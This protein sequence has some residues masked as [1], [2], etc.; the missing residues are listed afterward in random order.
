MSEISREY[1]KNPQSLAIATSLFS[2]MHA[3][4]R[5]YDDM[6]GAMGMLDKEPSKYRVEFRA[7]HPELA[8]VRNDTLRMYMSRA[9]IFGTGY[10]PEDVPAGLKE[11]IGIDTA[12][13]RGELEDLYRQG[14]QATAATFGFQAL[15]PTTYHELLAYQHGFIGETSFQ[16]FT[17]QEARA[18]QATLGAQNG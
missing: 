13:F 8:V 1:M 9:A 2:V 7:E 14:P 18:A 11:Q 12:N 17:E 6:L 10:T 5:A 4:E 15:R 3:E 16:S